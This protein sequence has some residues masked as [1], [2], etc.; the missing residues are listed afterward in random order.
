MELRKAK[1]V[2]QCK[3]YKDLGNIP[4]AQALLHYHNKL[5]H[6]GFDKLKDFANAGYLPSKIT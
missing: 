4:K 2:K 1:S 6:M 5:N 3:S